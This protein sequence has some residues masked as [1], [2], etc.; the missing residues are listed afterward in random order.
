[1]SLE[2]KQSDQVRDHS[3]PDAAGMEMAAKAIENAPDSAT[4]SVAPTAQPPVA[5]KHELAQSNSPT[6][7]S[8]ELSGQ[9]VAD[10]RKNLMPRLSL[11]GS[12]FGGYDGPF[13]DGFDDGKSTVSRTALDHCAVPVR[14][15]QRPIPSGTRG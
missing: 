1:M 10:A 15:W 7:L 12:V 5:S 8:E 14:A 11:N 4:D 2:L 13:S 6:L 3:S 9:V